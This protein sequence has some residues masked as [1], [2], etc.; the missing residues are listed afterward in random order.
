M[1][2]VRASYFAVAVVVLAIASATMARGAM[3]ADLAFDSLPSDQGWTYFEQGLDADGETNNY[4]AT[5]T[6]LE[7][8]RFGGGMSSSFD[9]GAF[10]TLSDPVINNTEP[11]YVRLVTQVLEHEAIG[12]PGPGT[13][14]NM[15]AYTLILN[16][17]GKRFALGASTSQVFVNENAVTLPDGTDLS[18]FNTFDARIDLQA[19]TYEAF[20]NGTPVATGS[21]ATIVSGTY[22]EF[23]DVTTYGNVD[24]NLKQLTISHTPIPEPASLVLLGLG[25]LTFLSRRSAKPRV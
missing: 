22:I 6:T 1:G 19:N 9:G 21:L 23:G 12:S 4:N 3:I 16:L 17:D 8:R 5:G 11:V 13:W 24:A 14:G 18:Q 2:A 10:Y 25:G 15:Y 20:I 7:L